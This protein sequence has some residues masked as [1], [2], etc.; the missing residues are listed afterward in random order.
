MSEETSLA[1]ADASGRNKGINST[2]T[3]FAIEGCSDIGWV[4]VEVRAEET[5]LTLADASGKN[6]GINSTVTAFAIE[7]CSGVGG[8]RVSLKSLSSVR[9]KRQ[10][11]GHKT[12]EKFNITER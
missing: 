3:A 10:P 4:E 2:V 6:K 5:S 11:E 9:K 7:G 12:A 8:E 1:L